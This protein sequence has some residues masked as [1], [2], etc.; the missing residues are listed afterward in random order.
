MASTSFFLSRNL[1]VALLGAGVGLT[2]AIAAPLCKPVLA[3]KQVR[4]SQVQPETM[5]RIWSATLAVDASRCA[6]NSGRFEILFSRMKENAPEVDFTERFVW[7]PE[8]VDVSV[9]FWADEAV[10]AYWLRNI[11][12]CPCRD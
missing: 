10:E 3:F 11:A 5:E 6:T 7:K 1:M 8:S 9:A 4:F 12:A 2:P